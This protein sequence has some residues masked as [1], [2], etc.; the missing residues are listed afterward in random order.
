MTQPQC[1]PYLLVAAWMVNAALPFARAC[2]K[3]VGPD[4]LSS[5]LIALRPLCAHGSGLGPESGTGRERGGGGGECVCGVCCV[6]VWPCRRTSQRSKVLV[7]A[8][9]SEHEIVPG[10]RTSAVSGARNLFPA[11]RGCR[12]QFLVPP[13]A[14]I[15]Y[16]DGALTGLRSCRVTKPL[17]VS[18]RT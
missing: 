13:H 12:K 11:A 15:A 18:P 4:N 7:G 17:A 16:P 8:V 5:F 14:R 1:L 9:C 2:K 3:G 10:R 6:C